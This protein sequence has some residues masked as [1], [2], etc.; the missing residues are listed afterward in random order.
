MTSS[1]Y[2]AAVLLAGALLVAVL[3]ASTTILDAF[4]D[5]RAR[6]RRE[7]AEL[8]AYREFLDGRWFR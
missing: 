6:R 4:L 8:T 1:D 2:A 3:A 5:A 7:R